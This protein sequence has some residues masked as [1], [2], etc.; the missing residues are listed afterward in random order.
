M[1]QAIASWVQR[2]NPP[3]VVAL[4]GSGHLRYGRGVPFQLRDLGVKGMAVALA[5]EPSMECS[6]LRPGLAD[7]VFGIEQRPKADGA[8]R[9]RLGIAIEPGSGGVQVRDVI[10]GSI[11]EHAGLQKGDVI[12][13]IA[14]EPVRDAGDVIAAVRRQAPGTWLPLQVTRGDATLE[15]VARFPPRKP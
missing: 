1:A 7:A 12:T 11:A 10:K 6:T 8:D 3:L 14:G 2:P 9:P 4:M 5:W 15:I 13:L